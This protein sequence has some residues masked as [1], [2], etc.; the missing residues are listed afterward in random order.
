MARRR[1][2]AAVRRSMRANRAVGSKPEGAM[3]AALASLG[4]TVRRNVR[5]LPG[6][7]DVV[8]EAIS[9]CVMVHGCFWHG[10]PSHWRPPKANRTYWVEKVRRNRARDK[11]ARVALESLGWKVVEIWEHDV[12]RDA[13]AAAVAA[14]VE[15]RR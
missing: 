14:V 15:A 8:V 9:L 10:C 4:L 3:A 6:T 13:R 11:A 7:P 2:R 12:R 5:G 1:D